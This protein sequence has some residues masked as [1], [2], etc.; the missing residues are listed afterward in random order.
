MPEIGIQARPRTLEEEN[1]SLR[2]VADL[3]LAGLNSL[4]LMAPAN[5]E[6]VYSAAMGD[7]STKD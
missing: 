5:R 4:R 3:E 6:A 1:Y 7:N 2:Y